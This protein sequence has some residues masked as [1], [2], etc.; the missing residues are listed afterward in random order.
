MDTST[1]EHLIERYRRGADL[2]EA[3]LAGLTDDDLDRTPAEGGWSARRVAHHLADS[4]MTSA[5]RLRRLLT[6]DGPVIQAYDENAYADQL[7]YDDRPIAASLRAM[8]AARDTSADL[9]ERLT[10]EQWQRTGT[11]TE[12]GAYG[13]TTWLEIYA[14][15]AEDHARQIEQAARAASA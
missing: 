14:A 8:R 5:I 3:A 11:H 7:S 4:E 10:D 2:V 12:S 1:R 13:V 9:L 6:E 15:H